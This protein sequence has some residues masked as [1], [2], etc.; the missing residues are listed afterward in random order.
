MEKAKFAVGT[1][2]MLKGKPETKGTV[3]NV[4]KWNPVDPHG[5]KGYVYAFKS[6]GDGRSYYGY[7]EKMLEAAN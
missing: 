1:E 2:V 5:Y 4:C 6:H 7:K 3:T